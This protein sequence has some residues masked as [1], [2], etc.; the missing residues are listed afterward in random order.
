VIAD[1][2]DDDFVGK[3]FLNYGSNETLAIKLCATIKLVYL[4]KVHEKIRSK[5]QHN[6]D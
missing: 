2:Y 5:Y 1:D 6:L 3:N 4:R